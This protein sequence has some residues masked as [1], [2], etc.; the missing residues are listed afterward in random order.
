MEPRPDKPLMRGILSTLVLLGLL[1]AL[2]VAA[3]KGAPA[4]VAPFEGVIDMSLTMEAGSGDLMLSM[5][6]DRARLDMMVTVNPMPEPL[7][8]SVLLDAKTPGTVF[9]VNDRL[10][11]Y[12]PIAVA[13]SAA[14]PP[15]AGKYAIKVLGKEKILGYDCTHLTLTRDKELIDAW[16]TQD[17]PEVYRVLKRLQQANPQIAEAAAFRALDES[18]R[19][20]LP[21]RCTVVRDGQRVSTEVRRI[22]RKMM[23]ASLFAVPRD[24]KRSESG[25]GSLQPTPEQIEELKRMIEGALDSQ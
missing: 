21:M 7:K 9:L 16:I 8:M 20:G 4:P 5:A 13:D 14:A 22:T 18:G 12:S 19:S 1:A 10:K 2:G 17:L 3:P 11:T 23:P 6:G 24:Y 15:A 25:G